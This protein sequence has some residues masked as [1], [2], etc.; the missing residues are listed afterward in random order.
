M[1]RFDAKTSIKG[2]TTIPIEV[3]QALGLQPGG[4]VQFVVDEDGKVHVIAKTRGLKHLEGFL[5][6][7]GATSKTDDELIMDA[8]WEKNRPDNERFRP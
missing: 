1:G 8:V 7:L 3:R 2:Q 4:Q 6:H 5:S